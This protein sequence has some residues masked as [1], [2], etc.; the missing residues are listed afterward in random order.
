MVTECPGQSVQQFLANVRQKEQ[1]VG[2]KGMSETVQVVHGL[3]KDEI[4]HLD[5]RL[6][7]IRYLFYI[8]H[9]ADGCNKG[10]GREG[11]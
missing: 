1:F 8:V 2:V 11:G 7:I 9:Q 4:L 10:K 6:G 5:L 3:L